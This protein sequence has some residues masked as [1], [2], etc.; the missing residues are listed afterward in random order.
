[1]SEL[2]FD[3]A[4]EAPPFDSQEVLEPFQVVGTFPTPT[5][6]DRF[7]AQDFDGSQGWRVISA[8]GSLNGFNGVTVRVWAALD[9]GSM[10]GFV[11][12]ASFGDGGATPDKFHTYTVGVAVGGILRFQI[13]YQDT[14]GVPR[15]VTLSSIPIPTKEW[16]Q[17]TWTRERDLDTQVFAAYLDGVQ[18]GTATNTDQIAYV[19]DTFWTLGHR[20]TLGV[21]DA[22]VIGQIEGV[23]VLSR[24]VT[25]IEELLEYRRRLL[26]EQWR[27]LVGDALPR[28]RTV[29]ETGMDVQRGSTYHTIRVRPWADLLGHAA[30]R[31]TNWDFAALPPDCY[32][33]QLARFERALGIVTDQ[34]ASTTKRQVD[35]SAAMADLGGYTPEKLLSLA[36]TLTGDPSPV[37]IVGSNI[38]DPV[39]TDPGSAP[40]V[41]PWIVKGDGTVTLIPTGMEIEGL[42][43]ATLRIAGDAVTAAWPIAHE[44]LDGDTQPIRGGALSAKFVSLVGTAGNMQWTGVSILRQFEGLHLGVFFDGLLHF[45]AWRESVEDTYTTWTI[46]DN[47]IVGASV[48]V[49]Y[50]LLVG[51]WFATWNDTPADPNTIETAALPWTTR[52]VLSIALT[53]QSEA[54]LVADLTAVWLDPNIQVP[55]AETARKYF[56]VAV[57]ATRKD[58]VGQTAELR[59]RDRPTAIGHITYSLTALTDDSDSPADFTPLTGAVT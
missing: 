59:K 6:G 12:L 45:I 37:L 19:Q 29:T 8:P 50:D 38:F 44:R 1:M 53:N 55:N 10:A 48:G 33:S 56:L 27:D 57:N 23:D 7:P 11:A 41:N 5:I 40:V 4:A 25:S 42:T 46:L 20:Q 32:G 39:S 35:V 22:F 43:G 58:A 24:A 31:A 2:R 15:T 13:R 26:Q 52:D 30:A 16:S 9:W 21:T 34:S 14:S 49:Y 17:M 28:A 47:V 18:L 36:T 51:Q 3:S 54:T